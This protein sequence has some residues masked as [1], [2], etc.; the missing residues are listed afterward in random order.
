[1]SMKD[2]Y[3]RHLK[4]HDSAGFTP[5]YVPTLQE[6]LAKNDRKEKCKEEKLERDK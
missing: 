4:A 2:I 3:L 6:I 1:M 5:K